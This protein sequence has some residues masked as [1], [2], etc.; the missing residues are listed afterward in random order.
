M[1]FIFKFIDFT[2]V[3]TKT[4]KQIL[5]MFILTANII[6]SVIPQIIA[7]SQQPDF[8]KMI[9]QSGFVSVFI[10]IFFKFLCFF[11]N[12]RRFL[13]LL[14]NIDN[15]EY[16]L[17]NDD[18]AK[19]IYQNEFKYFLRPIQIYLFVVT[20][21]IWFAALIGVTKGEYSTIS[22]YGVKKDIRNP[23]F[24]LTAI[25]SALSSTYTGI[26]GI[27]M[28]TVPIVIYFE[29][30][31]KLQ[32]LQIYLE[33]IGSRSIKNKHL[34]KAGIMNTSDTKI[35]IKGIKTYEKIIDLVKETETAMN[36]IIFVQAAFGGFNLIA[37]LF[38]M[39]S[40]SPF[41]ET[42]DFFVFFLFYNLMMLDQWLPM[43]WANEVTYE[44]GNLMISVINSDWIYLS[45]KNK[46]LLMLMLERMKFP[47][48]IRCYGWLH[49]NLTTFAMVRYL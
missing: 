31:L 11:K 20:F 32:Q 38:K 30:K 47:L 10:F 45:L 2:G 4:W 41:T 28:D 3:W 44:S 42:S 23:I 18:A 16:N 7:T 5:L 37:A 6:I 27:V 40:L 25:H 29:L 36:S 9:Q 39:S 43:K 46:K 21:N 48:R 22:D 33:S 17:V 26:L 14:D 8:N 13:K 24:I 49:L 34:V 12:R 1:I 35:I 19:D 15:F